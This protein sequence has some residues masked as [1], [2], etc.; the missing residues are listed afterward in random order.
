[1]KGLRRFIMLAA[2]ETRHAIYSVLNFFSGHGST[3]HTSNN[4]T[5]IGGGSAT[6][7]AWFSCE[8]SRR[9]GADRSQAFMAAVKCR[10]VMIATKAVGEICVLCKATP[11]RNGK[12]CVTYS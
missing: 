3:K 4:T 12:K 2:T 5:N 11:R 10:K 6:V 1:M 9:Y 8:S 7:L